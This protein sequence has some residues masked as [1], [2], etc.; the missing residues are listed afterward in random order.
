MIA[1][2]DEVKNLF[3]K[4]P[5]VSFIGFEIVTFEEENVVIELK[6]RNE[7]LNVNDTVHGGIH[8]VMLDC[9]LGMT[10]RSLYRYPV[11]TMNLNIHYLASI[12]DG[13]MVAKAKIIQK[14]YRTVIAEGEIFNESGDLLAKGT[15]TFKINRK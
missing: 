5:F 9:I 10:I 6:V 7:L 1:T 12:S 14:G 4:S 3:E 8:A 11:I 13:K 2:L 15:G